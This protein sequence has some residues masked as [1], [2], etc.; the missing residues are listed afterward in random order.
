[1]FLLSP[2]QH[3]KPLLASLFPV[4]GTDRNGLSSLATLQL[5]LTAPISPG[6]RFHSPFLLP[7]SHGSRSTWAIHLHNPGVVHLLV[8]FSPIPL[9]QLGPRHL[10]NDSRESQV[11]PVSN[12][13]GSLTVLIS[14]TSFPRSTQRLRPSTLPFFVNPRTARIFVRAPHFFFLLDLPPQHLHSTPFNFIRFFWTI[15][16]LAESLSFRPHL[17]VSR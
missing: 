15:A 6:S 9:E 13:G 11:F 5:C 4:E 3:G 16:V 7:K 17:F 1:M 8:L 12:N 14:P 10:R 2:P